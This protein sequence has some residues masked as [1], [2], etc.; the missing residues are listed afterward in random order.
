MA[1]ILI[2]DD[3]PQINELIKLALVRDGHEVTVAGD[4]AQAID[5]ARRMVPDLILLDMLMP[6]M[7]GQEVLREIRA[8]PGLAHIPVVLATGEVDAASEIDGEVDAVLTKP[9]KLNQLYRVVSSLAGDS[10]AETTGDDAP[11]G[12]G[13]R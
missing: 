4:G 1:R 7:S 13:E 8:H 6:D 5:L 3:D 11:D 9:Y 12:A 2:V 10:C